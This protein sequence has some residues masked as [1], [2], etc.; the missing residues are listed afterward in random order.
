[1]ES[2]CEES[3]YDASIRPTSRLRKAQS[4]ERWF[5]LRLIGCGWQYLSL[6]SKV[7]GGRETKCWLVICELK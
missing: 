3:E 5:H 6:H 2:V 1:M 7:A 4:S